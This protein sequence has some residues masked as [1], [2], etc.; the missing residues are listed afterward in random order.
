MTHVP[1]DKTNLTNFQR[2][3]LNEKGLT[4]P[5]NGDIG[6]QNTQTSS[7]VFEV[8]H[9]ISPTDTLL[10]P[11][12]SDSQPVN[13][14]IDPHSLSP[15]MTA[16]AA[17]VLCNPL[18]LSVPSYTQMGGNGSCNGISHSSSNSTNLTENGFNSSMHI[19]RMFDDE[20]DSEH[21]IDE[22]RTENPSREMLNTST[23]IS[24]VYLSQTRSDSSLINLSLPVQKPPSSL[25]LLSE[26]SQ[27]CHDTQEICLRP[28]SN[29]C[30]PS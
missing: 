16:T 5:T 7:S 8:I 6:H 15:S 1:I 14:T 11:A 28:K 3:F 22:I 2:I 27:S 10:P 19:N 29:K 24:S 18:L 21:L 23:P 20:Q 4:R 12:P 30:S 13:H 26:V 25:N 17:A 9:S